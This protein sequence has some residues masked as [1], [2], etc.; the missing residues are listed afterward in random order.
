M[1][2]YEHILVERLDSGVALIRLNRPER[3][4]AIG[5]K[6][7]QE[8]ASAF[9]ALDEE[10][11]VM[12]VV[13]TGAGDRAFA[14]GQDLTE[15]VDFTPESIEGWIDSFNHLYSAIQNFDKATVAA[16]NGYAVGAGLQIALLCD[17]RIASERA[18]FGMPEIDD[19][20]PCI[21]GTWTL[22]ELVGRG[23]TADMIL[24]GRLL[25]ADEALQ[26]GLVSE[27]VSH[28]RL[29]EIAIRWAEQLGS[30][31]QLALR[32]NKQRLRELLA[33]ELDNAEAFAKWA[34]AECFRAGEAQAAITDFLE[35]RRES[36]SR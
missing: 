33:R 21:T 5:D 25:D 7:R 30:K 14:A 24:T 9:E 26:W 23:R 29:P 36:R 19:A 35:R 12:A 2:G 34:H 18:R 16:V 8:L 22:Y 13:L 27:V 10:S 28:E 32:L 3:L 15:A 1:R 11:T 6:M 17:L 20:V 4:N 31:S